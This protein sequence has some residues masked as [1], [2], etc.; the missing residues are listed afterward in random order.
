MQKSSNNVRKYKSKKHI[1][2]RLFKDINEESN[3]LKIGTK[4]VIIFKII[5][6]K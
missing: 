1:T 4:K 2:R 6:L 5:K 3:Q